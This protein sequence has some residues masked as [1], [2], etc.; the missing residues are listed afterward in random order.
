MRASTTRYSRTVTP[1]RFTLLA[2][3]TASCAA[4]LQV[5]AAEIYRWTDDQG[6]TH[7]SEVVP[8]KYRK[9]ARP[10]SPSAT[11]PSADQQREAQERSAREKARAAAIESADADPRRA[12]PP[13]PAAS[14]AV[15][16]R[17]SRVPDAR[18][19]CETWARL[20]K[21]SI[22][23]FAPFRTARGATRGEA[24]DF[25]TP[26]DEPPTSCRQRLP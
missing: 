24:F 8:E 5:G 16:K 11:N 17:P 10:V 26:V 15:Q 21:E 14:A 4:P 2:L 7:Y 22:D 13:A 19:D 9:T 18:T 6:Q 12:A 3:L 1:H 25:C 20:Y 23:C